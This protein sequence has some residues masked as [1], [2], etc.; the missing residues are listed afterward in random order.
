MD[1]SLRGWVAQNGSPQIVNDGDSDPRVAHAN[2]RAGRRPHASLVVPLKLRGTVTGVLGIERL[3]GRTFKEH[4]LEVAQLLANMAAIA[5]QNA[6]AYEELERRAISDG[7]TSLH[8]HRHFHETLD[9]ATRRGERYGESFCLLMLDLDHFKAVNDTVGHQKGDEVLRAVSDVLRSCSRE[10]DYLARYGGEEFAV[11][12]PAHGAA[13][14]RRA[15]APHQGR[16][17]PTSTS[18]TPGCT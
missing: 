17:S 3:G 11:I 18:A 5:I 8:N 7:L 1:D 10:T 16:A 12:L 4:E 6:Q 13:G 14:G 2:G 15:R 9:I